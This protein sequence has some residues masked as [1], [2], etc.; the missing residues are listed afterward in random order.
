MNSFL[1][2]ILSDGETYSDFDGTSVAVVDDNNL[3]L[4]EVSSKDWRFRE[5]YDLNN[6][7]HLRMLA[8]L[9]ERRRRTVQS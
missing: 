2:T 7:V 4:L 6:P 5:R 9:I 8:D 1:V 3:K